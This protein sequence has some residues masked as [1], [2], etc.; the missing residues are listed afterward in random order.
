MIGTIKNNHRNLSPKPSC[1][2]QNELLKRTGVQKL[3]PFKNS[4]P[5]VMQRVS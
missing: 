3:I 2:F 4:N 1:G 5:G